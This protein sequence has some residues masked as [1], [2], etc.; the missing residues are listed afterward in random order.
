MLQLVS[1][2]KTSRMLGNDAAGLLGL[3]V[4]LAPPDTLLKS[5]LAASDP[6]REL[7]WSAV[8]LRADPRMAKPL[9]KLLQQ[10]KLP[11]EDQGIQ[12]LGAMGGRDAAAY[13]FAQ[14]QKAEGARRTVLARAIVHTGVAK[15]AE[16][17]ELCLRSEATEIRLAALRQWAPLKE[18]AALSFLQ[19]QLDAGAADIDALIA[20]QLAVGSR[21]SWQWITERGAK[22]TA[23]TLVVVLQRIG[24]QQ[25]KEMEP[26]VLQRL[27]GASEPVELAA[28]RCLAAVGGSKSID[29]LVARSKSPS[30]KLSAEALKTLA[31]LQDSS[32]DARLKEAT[33]DPQ[34][35]FYLT[36]LE[37]LSLRNSPGSVAYFN[38]LFS[39][40]SPQGDEL[41]AG[42]RGMERLG[43]L[44]SVKL[45]VSRLG[46]EKDPA[47]VRTIQISIK[48]VAI[49]LEQPDRI[50]KEAILPALGQPTGGELEARILPLL[51]AVA[52]PEALALCIERVRGHDAVL[53]R[54][55]EQALIRWRSIEVCDYWLSVLQDQ[56]KSDADREQAIRCI[57][58][59]LRADSHSDTPKLVAEKAAEL[60]LA[61]ENKALRAKLLA[62][63]G[64]LPNRWKT[65]FYDKVSPH[66]GSLPDYR[67]QLEALNKKK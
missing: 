52:S 1:D 46:T 16:L 7:L 56:A 41:A 10:K 49:R 9:V 23:S 2:P 64:G 66:L 65:G 48:R 35:P 25:R 40:R 5:L 26:W 32:L 44:E 50:W 57:D 36:A 6:A 24:E 45:L 67:E 11:L 12:A 15:A 29:A 27:E 42:L 31:V 59:A 20:V 8:A 4:D 18:A 60:F 58:L 39:A 38:Q 22:L 51:D 53:A 33:A 55:A 19:S 62:M 3:L 17:K 43:N 47:V 14:W 61:S 63:V 21:A 28:V 34:H 13:L 37:L 30:S 54:A